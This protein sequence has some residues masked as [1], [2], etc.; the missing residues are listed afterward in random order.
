MLEPQR[1]WKGRGAVPAMRFRRAGATSHNPPAPAA[2]HVPPSPWATFFSAFLRSPAATNPPATTA[3]APT[4]CPASSPAD[5]DFPDATQELSTAP[6][7]APPAISIFLRPMGVPPPPF[8][9]WGR[10]A[11]LPAVSSRPDWTSEYALII[12]WMSAVAAC[13]SRVREGMATLVLSSSTVSWARQ[14]T[15]RISQ[16]W[17]PREVMLYTVKQFLYDV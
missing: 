16:R 12:H 3:T 2:G 15:P 8:R 5:S 7:T 4:N 11:A 9:Q 17:G 14:M 6:S 1:P 13:S 10:S